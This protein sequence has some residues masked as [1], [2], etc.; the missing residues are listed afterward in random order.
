MICKREGADGRFGDYLSSVGLSYVD[1]HNRF[2][3]MT[4]NSTDLRP[5]SSI[6]EI[7]YLMELFTL[8]TFTHSLYEL[9]GLCGPPR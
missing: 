1:G 6:L 2:T 4:Q 7:C 8:L 9:I 3:D 5:K